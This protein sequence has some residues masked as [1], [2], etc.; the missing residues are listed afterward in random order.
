MRSVTLAA[1]TLAACDAMT[2]VSAPV[3]VT[4]P[5]RMTEEA[6]LAKWGDIVTQVSMEEMMVEHGHGRNLQG[7]PFAMLMAAIQQITNTWQSIV[8]AFKSSYKEEIVDKQCARVHP[9]GPAARARHPWLRSTTYA[10]PTC[11]AAEPHPVP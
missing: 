8:N 7:N 10:P 3:N 11:C 6:F 5:P 9:H 2:T 1:L 4:S